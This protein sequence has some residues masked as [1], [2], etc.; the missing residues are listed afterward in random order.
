LGR[1]AE[2]SGLRF[3]QAKGRFFSPHGATAPSGSGP[4]HYRGFTISL[5]HIII[6]RS[7]LDEWSARRRDFYLTTHNTH[8]RQISV[9][10]A[11]FEPATPA[12]E[13]PLT[14][15]DNQETPGSNPNRTVH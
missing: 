10:P 9:P 14:Q 1:E 13:R 6:S 15:P 4:P 12:S 2:G 7:L 3:V 11:G 8:K 5:R